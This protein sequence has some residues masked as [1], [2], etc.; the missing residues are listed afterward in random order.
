MLLYISRCVILLEYFDIHTVDLPEIF[1]HQ[2]NQNIFTGSHEK[3]NV[4]NEMLTRG[5][6]MHS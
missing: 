2:F 4:V 5:L 3:K 1:L 6:Q